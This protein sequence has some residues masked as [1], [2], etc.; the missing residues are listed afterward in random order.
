MLAPGPDQPGCPI[1][2]IME[3]P[4]SKTMDCYV[5]LWTPEAAVDA[6]KK[7]EQ[8]I[9]F[10]N[11]PK[12]GSRKVW[13]RV[14]GQDE[15]LNALFPRARGLVWENGVPRKIPNNDPYSAGFQ[16]FF[17]KEEVFGMQRHAEMPQRVSVPLHGHLD[18]FR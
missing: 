4:T 1:H 12:I 8:M 15:L 18:H 11:Q 3:R 17:T 14:S 13:A 16:G 7:C 2:I 9:M 10:G 5:E 6:Y